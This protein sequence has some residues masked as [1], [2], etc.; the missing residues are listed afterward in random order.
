LPAK[1]GQ[2]KNLQWLNLWNNI[3]TAI[4]PE[5]GQ[6]KTLEELYLSGNNLT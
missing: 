1:I 5:I 2:L 6:L 3:I 4:P